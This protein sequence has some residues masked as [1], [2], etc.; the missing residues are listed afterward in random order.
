MRTAI[1][2]FGFLASLAGPAL[3]QTAAPAAEAPAMFKIFASSAD[4][5]A[6][7]AKAKAARKPGQLLVNDT[8]VR[9]PPYTVS[10]A[11]RV[12][13][14]LPMVHEKQA[15]LYYVLEG[16]GTITSGGTMVNPTRL[17]GGNLEGSAIDGGTAQILS[18]GDFFFVPENTPHGWTAIPES[19][20]T[21]SLHLP[22]PAPPQ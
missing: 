6:L 20:V 7:I 12:G 11:Y 21:L 16:T 15:E 1:P 19:M 5:E 14:E 22:R 18:K 8:I 4:V 10:L 3:A 17:N 13:A 2:L 9:L